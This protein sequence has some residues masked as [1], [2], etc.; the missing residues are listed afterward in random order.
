MLSDM[1]KPEIRRRLTRLVPTL[2]LPLMLWACASAPV[3]EWRSDA[4]QSLDRADQQ[5]RLAD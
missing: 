5:R 2:V 4:E 3:D 1:A